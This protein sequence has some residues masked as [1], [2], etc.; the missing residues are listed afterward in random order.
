[1]SAFALTPCLYRIELPTHNRDSAFRYPLSDTSKEA[2]DGS[3]VASLTRCLMCGPLNAWAVEAAFDHL[4]PKVQLGIQ[5]AQSRAQT[6]L[7][8]RMVEGHV[9]HLADGHLLLMGP[10]Q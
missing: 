2:T 8:H 9:E 1:M 3:P 7:D 5:I 6:L 10:G 4:G